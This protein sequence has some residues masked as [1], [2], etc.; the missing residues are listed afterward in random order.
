[1]QTSSGDT[2]WQE[3]SFSIDMVQPP[4][5][6]LSL[7]HSWLHLSWREG[8]ATVHV[9]TT[10][11]HP[12]QGRN[13][14]EFQKYICRRPI[15]RSEYDSLFLNLTDV[16]WQFDSPTRASS[17]TDNLQNLLPLV[18]ERLAE[19]LR[20]LKAIIGKHQTLNSVDILGAA[21]AVIS[22]VKGQW[23]R[24]GSITKH[25]QVHSQPINVGFYFSSGGVGVIVHKILWFRSV[26]SGFKGH[27]MFSF[28]FRHISHCS[29]KRNLSQGCS[30][31]RFCSIIFIPFLCGC[32]RRVVGSL[33]VGH[34]ACLHSRAACAFVWQLMRAPQDVSSVTL[35]LRVFSE[36]ICASIGNWVK[37]L[38]CL[39]CVRN[40]R[41]SF[42]RLYCHCWKLNDRT[43][44]SG[45]ARKELPQCKADS[46][47]A[48][49]FV[50]MQICSLWLCN[51]EF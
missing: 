25:L 19:L 33:S 2:I 14:K 15:C 41:D 39:D 18:H 16:C 12:C 34:S 7:P 37:L 23:K 3:D 17:F 21:G 5:P 46:F 43:G 30:F 22:K 11:K 48:N 1:M 6:P 45:T 31:A 4:T 44:C 47:R 27:M 26:M 49:F 20:V 38:Q 24:V 40:K 36:D 51:P 29:R 10:E 32:G 13:Q 35:F 28:L 42:S 50:E 9:D 8:G